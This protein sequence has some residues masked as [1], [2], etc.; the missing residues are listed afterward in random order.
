MSIPTLLCGRSGEL[1]SQY[2]SF[3]D[4]LPSIFFSKYILLLGAIKAQLSPFLHWQFFCRAGPFL[5]A[6]ELRIGAC[7][8]ARQGMS[9]SAT[10]RAVSVC[11]TELARDFLGFVEFECL[12]LYSQ[13]TKT[14][15]YAFTHSSESTNRMQQSL[16]FI[17]C[18]LNIAQHV[19]GIL[20]PIIRSPST[21]AAASGLP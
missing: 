1:K 13:N 5:S 7:D 6:T 4:G 18:R 21:A 11:S 12:F 16:R 10:S 2:V 15:L 17:A 9:H 8:I 20:L 14:G 19:S 3:S